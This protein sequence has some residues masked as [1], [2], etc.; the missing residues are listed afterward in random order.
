[1]I[2]GAQYYRP[3]NPPHED[4]D[5]DLERM[6]AA[7]FDTVKLWACWSWMQPTPDAIDFADL[8]RLFDLA[9]RH[10]LG[11]VVNTILE[12]VPYW[13]AA[14]HPAAHYHDHEQRPVRLTA[15]MNTP[16][17]GWPGLCFDNPAVWEAAASFLTAVVER[18]RAHPALRVWD[19]WNEPHLEPASYFP[20]RLYCYC[21]ASVATFVAGLRASYGSLDAL[22]DAWS[23]RFSSW[24]QVEPPRLFEAVPDM[25]D[26]R[27]HWFRNLAG[28]LDRRCAVVRA[29]DPAHPVMTHV[30]LSGFTGQLA[31]HTLDEYTLT[32]PIDVFGTSSFPTWLM[33]DDHVEHLFNLD[34]ARGAADGKPFWQAELQGG[35]GRRDGRRS[36]PHPVPSTVALWMWNALAAGASGVVF[37]QWRPELLGPE[38]PGYGLCA[39]EGSVTTRVAAA[40]DFAAA[41]RD[42]DGAVAEPGSVGLLVSRES[43]LHAFATDRSMSLYRDAILGA[44]RLLLDADLPIEILHADRVA[45]DGVPAHIRSLYWPMPSV[46]TVELGSS[47]ADFVH[48]GGTLVSEAAPGE[49]DQLGRRRP[50]VPGAGMAELFGARQVDADIVTSV[51]VGGLTGTWQRETLAVADGTVVATFSDGTPGIV[52]KSGAVLVATYPSLSYATTA[53][54]D[55]RSALL[56]LLAPERHRTLTWDLPGPGLLHRVLTTPDGGRVVVAVNW[57]NEEQKAVLGGAGVTVP[58]RTGTLFPM[59]SS[60]EAAP[61]SP[62]I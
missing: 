5:R 26:W 39:P 57:T 15:A 9:H 28:W 41:V 62:R 31:T 20:D 44:Y 29:A 42:L 53:D 16:G 13:L 17:G 40:S 35:R 18:Y 58:A 25:I 45:A 36:T 1:M 21:D 8:D 38:S 50:T 23:R 11:V 24:D 14:L 22:N 7:G 33:A 56:A 49:H 10:G 3:P 48:H 51:E 34:T 37:W 27:S 30:A 43:A 54:A 6:R 47:L 52:R 2:I 19:V 55:T 4:W 61:P 46:V 60:V 12:N 59:V 32:S